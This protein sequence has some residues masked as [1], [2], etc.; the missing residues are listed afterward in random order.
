MSLTYYLFN[1]DT[2][3]GFAALNRFFDDAFHQ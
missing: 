1:D 2:C 3:S